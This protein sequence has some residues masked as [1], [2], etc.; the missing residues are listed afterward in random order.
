MPSKS[1]V[2]FVWFPLHRSLISNFSLKIAE[3]FADFSKQNFAK[4]IRIFAEFLLNLTNFFRDFPQMQHFSEN[5]CILGM[6]H[7]VSSKVQGTVKVR[8]FQNVWNLNSTRI[9]ICNPGNAR[10]CAWNLFRTK[11]AVVK[12]NTLQDDDPW[13]ARSVTII[14]VASGV[15]EHEVT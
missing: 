2:L 1:G 9:L 7:A 15:I 3:Y 8:K 4:F 6:R 14:D 13:T 12:E 10:S 5:C 11:I